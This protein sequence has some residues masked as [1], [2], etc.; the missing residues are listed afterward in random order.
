MSEQL[1]R[2]LVRISKAVGA[3]F[4]QDV[5]DGDQEFAGNGDDSLVASQAWFQASQHFAPMRK[6]HRAV[7]SVCGDVRS[8][9]QPTAAMRDALSGIQPALR[10]AGQRAG[11]ARILEHRRYL[12]G[13]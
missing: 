8:R 5:P 12:G 9:A 13:A 2:N 6:C 7:S 4:G 3:L 1:A 10:G 11:H